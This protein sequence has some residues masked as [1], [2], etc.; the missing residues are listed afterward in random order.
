MCLSCVTDSQVLSKTLSAEN[1]TLRQEKLAQ[2]E[3]I[4]SLKMKVV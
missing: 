1:T 3:T 4:D 2:E